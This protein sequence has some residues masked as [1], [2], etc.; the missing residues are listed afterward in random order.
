MTRW[1]VVLAGGVGSR[2][3]P[4]STPQRPKQLLPLATTDPMLADA[5]ARLA[6]LVPPER[7]LV[8]TNA[9]LV[10]AIAA[11]APTLPR[12]NL[13]AEPRP[14]GTA[15][16]LA[17]AAHEIVRRG[18]REDVMISVHADWA[19]GDAE[20]FRAALLAAAGVAES[21]HALVTVGVVPVRPDPGFGYIQPGEAAGPVA[22]RVA[23]FVEKP[24]RARAETMLREGYLWNSGIFVWR[25]GDFLDEITALTPEIAPHL[26]AHPDDLA[27]FFAA[28]TTGISVDVGVME[29]SARV[30]VLAGDFGWD[31]V[32]TWAALRRVRQCDEGGNAL[33]GAVHAIDATNN[34]VHADG[35]AVVLYGVSDLVV[36]SRAGLTLVTTIERAA[37]LKK[38]IASLPPTLRDQS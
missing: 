38:L 16:A 21:Q 20:G 26:A 17:W 32:G 27:K 35:N 13:I 19:I 25:A 14:A 30:L 7:T 37:D 6:P 10:D 9:G 31:D 15:A 33:S 18:A 23:R 24:D 1:A 34:V 22:R 12:E 36:V 11:L 2:F 4:I 29:R 28:I 3:W 5:L 8:L